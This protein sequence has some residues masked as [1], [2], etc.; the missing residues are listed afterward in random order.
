METKNLCGKTRPKENP[1]EIW[2]S[3]DGTWQWWV[4]KKYKSPAG[5]SKDPYA[6]WFT[7]VR[8]PF[9]PDFELGDTYVRE[10]RDNACKLNDQEKEEIIKAWL[11]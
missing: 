5:E 6:R 9:V 7:A 1:Y 8:S 2:V 4:L 11:L 10:I 3:F